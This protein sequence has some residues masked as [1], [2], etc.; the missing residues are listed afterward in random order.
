MTREELYGT[1][2]FVIHGFFSGEQCA[3]MIAR[4]EQAGYEDAPITTASGPV[5]NKGVRNN[6]RVMLDDVQLAAELWER[7][8]PL[9][10]ARIGSRQAVGFNERFRFYR[11]DVAEQFA[12]HLDGAYYRDNGD[13]SLLTLMVYLNEDFEG[14]ATRFF[15]WHGEEWLRVRPELGKALVFV[16]RQL[17]EGAPVVSGRKYVLR[18]DVMYRRVK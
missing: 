3:G 1:N 16:H 10:P 14:G 13:E 15:R 4:S 7:A 8:A 2:V 18:T 12:I 6:A 11:Y 5:M 17:H 9:L